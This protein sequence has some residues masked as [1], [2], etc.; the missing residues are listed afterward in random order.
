MAL[1][2][3]VRTRRRLVT[4]TGHGEARMMHA[5]P[6]SPVEVFAHAIGQAIALLNKAGPV[7]SL[8]A[9]RLRAR[10]D[11][12]VPQDPAWNGRLAAPVP[13]P[14]AA[15]LSRSNGRRG[16]RGKPKARSRRNRQLLLLSLLAG[17]GLLGGSVL[18]SGSGQDASLPLA[19]AAPGPAAN[20][21]QRPQAVPRT[22]IARFRLVIEVVAGLRP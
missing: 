1:E 13:R 3:V 11:T 5:T 20:A 22:G 21:A 16:M 19:Q 15:R 2:L 12:R 8:L 18:A 9:S 10:T 6:A 14:K 4:E 7:A 17:A